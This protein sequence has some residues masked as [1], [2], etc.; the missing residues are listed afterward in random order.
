MTA[1]ARS[2]TLPRMMKALNSLSMIFS[3]EIMRT[4]GGWILGE[5]RG[6]VNNLS[7]DRNKT[8]RE[9]LRMEM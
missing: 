1:M 3:F 2:S 9:N 4:N 7:G 5:E 8:G 6:L